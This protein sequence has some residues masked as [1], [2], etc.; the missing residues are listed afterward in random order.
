VLVGGRGR[1]LSEFR[2]LAR[3]AGLEIAAAGTNRAGRFIVEC[4]PAGGVPQSTP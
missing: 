2:S 4:T 3:A 1:S